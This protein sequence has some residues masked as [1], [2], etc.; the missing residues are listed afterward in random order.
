MLLAVA[1]TATLL[2]MVFMISGVMAQPSPAPSK[3]LQTC[4]K[5]GVSPPSAVMMEV[6]PSPSERMCPIEMRS[7]GKSVV[8]RMMRF[9]GTNS[10]TR[11]RLPSPFCRLIT[12][13]RLSIKRR[14]LSSA[15]RE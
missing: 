6:W 15:A 8:P 1:F 12:T 10:L 11:S 4:C 14:A 9:L 3:R 7:L 2:Q 13:V 5:K